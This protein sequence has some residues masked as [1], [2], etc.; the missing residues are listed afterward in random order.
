VNDIDHR[1]LGNKLDLFH[2]QEEGPG[3][4]FWHPRGWELYRVLEDYIRRRMRRAG[5]R[6]I[7][8]P[9][10]LARSIWERS[11][12]W[13]KF[14]ANMYSLSEGQD[15]GSANDERD[16]D[17]ASEARALCLK[18]MS[19]PCHVQVFN[20]RV[21][22]YRELPVRYSEFGACHRDEPS[23]SLEG[24][25]RT[26]AFVQ[27]DAHLFCTEAQIEV[28]VG[29]FCD[30]LR[31]VYADLGFP[32]FSV[33]LATRPALRA[34]ADG[35]W[36]RAEAAL[37]KAALAAGLQFDVREGEGAFYGPKVEF[38]LLDSRARSWQC[39]TI[40]LDFV[41][42]ERL[43]A[44]YVNDRNERERPVMIHH[45]VLGSME[46]FIAMLLEHHEGWL[47]LWLAPEQV[48]VATIN[49]ASAAYAAQVVQA[50]E[51]AGVRVVLDD[52][53]ERLEKKI[54]DAREK[55]VPVFVA[56]GPRDER[57]R[58]ISI[59]ERD[60]QQVVL[61]LAEGVER[62]RIAGLAPAR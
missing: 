29:R 55:Q 21:R 17:D 4:V 62:L 44:Q 49:D 35:V 39:G 32:A 7:R 8:T 9:Q 48:A 61:A 47:P 56:V 36:D 53:P 15:S 43:D 13:E 34:G 40:Q 26:R 30:L 2:Q 19:C 54:V 50:L 38:H 23:G 22:S 24:L 31:N 42:P 51:E 11:G 52:R 16:A 27:D 12:H 20:Q 41:L 60:G 37:A 5:F 25:K 33:A 58:T 18:P 6:E 45:A 59:R 14:G 10:L 3:M 28:E 46:R 1:V 57:D